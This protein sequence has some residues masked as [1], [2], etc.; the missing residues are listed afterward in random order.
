MQKKRADMFFTISALNDYSAFTGIF[1]VSFI[2]WAVFGRVTVS[3]PFLN[4]ALT[5]SIS[6]SAGNAIKYL[7][8]LK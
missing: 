1:F 3:T 4:S 6:I 5:L 2:A 8:Q 7:H